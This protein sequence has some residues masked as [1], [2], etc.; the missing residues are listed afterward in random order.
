MNDARV[1][2]IP[3]HSEQEFET[4]VETDQDTLEITDFSPHVVDGETGKH[5]SDPTDI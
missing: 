2:I 5:L 4:A 1:L 3:T